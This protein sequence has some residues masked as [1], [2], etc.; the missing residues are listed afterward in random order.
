MAVCPHEKASGVACASFDNEMVLSLWKQNQTCLLS[1]KP[2]RSVQVKSCFSQSP[3]KPF[4]TC[5][6][7]HVLNHNR[8]VSNSISKSSSRK[9]FNSEKWSMVF[10]LTVWCYSRNWTKKIL[11]AQSPLRL[12]PQPLWTETASVCFSFR[13]SHLTQQNKKN[14]PSGSCI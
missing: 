13:K 11:T 14:C 7:S 6:C 9:N 8:M 3:T 5:V 10:F 1:Q 2:N 4:C 12:T